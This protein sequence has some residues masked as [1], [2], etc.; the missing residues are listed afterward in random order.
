MYMIGQ[1]HVPEVVPCIP[2][3]TGGKKVVYS[4]LCVQKRTI[5]WWICDWVSEIWI[6]SIIANSEG[7]ASDLV[8]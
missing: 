4:I 1:S 7:K 2:Q 6:F 3:N 8:T 5:F